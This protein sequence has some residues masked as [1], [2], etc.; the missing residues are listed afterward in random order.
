MA[1][2]E[3]RRTHS[4]PLGEVRQ[5]AEALA[6]VIERKIGIRWW[7]HDDAI[8]FDTPAGAARGTTG[9][10]DVSSGEVRVR[11]DLPLVLVGFKRLV[12]SKVN[13]KF[14]AAM[15]VRN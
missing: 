5:K 7:W 10:V 1:T 14:D 6:S 4:L 13:A 3:L 9:R 12:E 15:G 11:I 2:I 8:Q